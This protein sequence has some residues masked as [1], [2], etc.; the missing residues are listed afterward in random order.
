MMGCK[1][2]EEGGKQISKIEFHSFESAI[3]IS[4]STIKM[5]Y[6]HP[7]FSTG[8]SD[9]SLLTFINFK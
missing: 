1:S 5:T 6:T 3:I 8:I 7:C 4:Y 9:P 2:I